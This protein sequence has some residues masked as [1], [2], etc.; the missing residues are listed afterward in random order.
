MYYQSIELSIQLCLLIFFRWTQMISIRFNICRVSITVMFITNELIRS[1]ITNTPN[2]VKSSLLDVETFSKDAHRDIILTINEGLSKASERIKYD[3]ESKVL[4]EI[5]LVVLLYVCS[6]CM[7]WKKWIWNQ[8]VISD[9]D[10]L[11]GDPIQKKI[12]ADSG[13]K[14]TLESILTICSGI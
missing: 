3:L 4:I 12:E 8:F 5:I 1:T 6:E 14:T 9:V 2:I 13:L 11:L 7:Q 10:K